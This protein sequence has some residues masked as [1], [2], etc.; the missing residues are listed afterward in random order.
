VDEASG[1]ASVIAYSIVQGGWRGEGVRDGDPR[2]V[3]PFGPDGQPGTEDDDLRLAAG[4]PAVDAGDVAALPA[5]VHDLDGDGDLEEPVPLDLDGANRFVDDPGGRD[6]G[7]GDR[8]IVDLG[9]FERR[10]STCPD[11]TG[12]G[13][14]DVDDLVAVVLAWGDAA[15]PADLNGDGIVDVDDLVAVVTGWG[16]CAA[17]PA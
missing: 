6:T 5:D 2:F 12:D 14:V 9:A 11:A 3:S 13:V 17:G 15:G 1:A 10:P 16:A 7:T 4:S 8:P